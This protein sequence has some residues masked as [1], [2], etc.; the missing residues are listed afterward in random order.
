MLF[1]RP[2]V[3][4]STLSAGAARER[5]RAFATSRDLPS[6]DAFRRRQIIGWKLSDANEDFVFQPEYGDTLNVEGA[7]LVA[8]VEPLGSGSRIRG[9]VV[10]SPITRIVMSVFLSAVVFAATAALAQGTEPAAKVLAIASLMLGGALLMVRYN[11]R[12]TSAIV[13]DRLRQCLDAARPRA[14]A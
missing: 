6:L 2:L 3:I 8:L 14:V 5:I 12:S 4:E 9:R 1:S 11:L 13:E 10:A 7:R